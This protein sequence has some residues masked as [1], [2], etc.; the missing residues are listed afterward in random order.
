[1]QIEFS[2]RISTICGHIKLSLH[3]KICDTSDTIHFRSLI[4]TIFLHLQCQRP[5]Q[6]YRILIR[7]S[8]KSE[9]FHIKNIRKQQKNEKMSSISVFLICSLICVSLSVADIL[10]PQ[11]VKRADDKDVIVLTD[12]NFKT[13]VLE[14]KDMW[15]VEFYAP[16]CGY[17][18]KLAPHWA[19]AATELKGKVKLGALDATKYTSTAGKYSISGYPTIKMFPAGKKDN[20]NF[21]EYDGGSTAKDIVEWAKDKL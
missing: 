20:K 8:F 15:L 5:F 13:K 18:K 11:R 7:L 1:M 6:R 19:K 17:C 9:F 21:Q 4:P 16:W 2:Y 12:D 10:E 14:S 3:I